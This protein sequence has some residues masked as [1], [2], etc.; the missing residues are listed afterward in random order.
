MNPLS[1]A[2]K[3]RRQAVPPKDSMADLAKSLSPEQKAEL[4]EVLQAESSESSS[5]MED[6]SGQLKPTPGEKEELSSEMDMGVAESM[7]DPNMDLESEPKDF[8]ERA[9][10]KVTKFMKGKGY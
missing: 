3:K 9:K 4:L 8:I 10:Q 5:D 1:E 6:S 7:F 2:I